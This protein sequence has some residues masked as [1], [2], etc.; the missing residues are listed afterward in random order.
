MISLSNRLLIPELAMYQVISKVNWF[1][2]C[3]IDI[4]IDNYLADEVAI[5]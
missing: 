1:T 4:A 3:N 2:G 5:L